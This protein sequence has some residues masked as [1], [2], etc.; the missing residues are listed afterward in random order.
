MGFCFFFFIFGAWRYQASNYEI[1][2]NG[3]TEYWG[4]EVIFN[5]SIIEKPESRQSNSR[6]E[7]QI[8]GVDAKVLVTAW[9]Y[10]EYNYGDKL[11]IE[12]KLEKPSFFEG[13]DY[14]PYLGKDG[15][16]AVMYKPKIELL[17]KNTRNPIKKNLIVFKE[18]LRKSIDLILPSPQSGL[19]EALF[20]G[21]EEN[22]SK[23]WINKFNDTGTRHIT[24]VSGMNITIISSLV[25]NLFL[26]L[27]LWRKQAFYFSIIF[28]IFYVSIIGA[29]SAAVRA[30]IMGIIFLISQYFGRDSSGV[31]IIV[32]SAFLMLL[33]NPLLLILDIGFQL[34]FLAILG[35][36]Y[37]QPIFYNW[38]Q[39]IPNVFEMRYTLSATLAAQFFTLPISVYNFGRV[40]LVGPLVNL[41]IVP[42]ITSITILGFIL[43]FIGLIST[44][45]GIALSFP[46]WLVLTYI[47]KIINLSS[48]FPF[49]NIIWE[50]VSL[51]WVIIAYF[52]LGFLI[53]KI[54]KKREI[55]V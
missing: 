32:I 52:V 8:E 38:F 4:E 11:R 40:S 41:L 50:G 16:Y 10:P 28:V 12:G 29:P 26:I 51:I 33:F 39:K 3:L 44:N 9:K 7:V 13:F 49:Y 48:Y 46:V 15:I 45:L 36:V 54:N 31:R 14:Q 47:L 43:S 30:G 6:I 5:G 23:E 21:D 1:Y 22:I 17:E 25:L 18:K 27:G 55:K 2:H 42:L 20:F 37:L 19:L 34:S 53:W 24:A 35:L